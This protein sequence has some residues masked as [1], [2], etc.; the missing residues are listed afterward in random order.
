MKL[1]DKNVVLKTLQKCRDSEVSDGIIGI[2]IK[3][4]YDAAMIAISNFVPEVDVSRDLLETEKYQI[5]KKISFEYL[6][7]DVNNSIED[8]EDRYCEEDKSNALINYLYD[9]AE[10]I[11]TDISNDKEYGSIN[12]NKKYFLDTYIIEYIKKFEEEWDTKNS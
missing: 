1:I 5:F 12:I 9:N 3:A 6:I 2:G 10:N 7:E 11:A 8:F 4:G